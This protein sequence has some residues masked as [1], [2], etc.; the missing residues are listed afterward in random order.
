MGYNTKRERWDERNAVIIEIVHVSVRNQNRR[1][2]REGDVFTCSVWLI[3][4]G[5]N[6]PSPGINKP[7]T[8]QK[9]TTQPSA[10]FYKHQKR[11]HWS[12]RKI[13]DSGEITWRAL[14]EKSVSVWVWMEMS[15]MPEKC[16][17]ICVSFEFWG[18][19]RCVRGRRVWALHKHYSGRN[20]NA[21]K[22]L[23]DFSPLPP[24]KGSLQ[25][26]LCPPAV[27]KWAPGFLK[28]LLCQRGHQLAC[29]KFYHQLAALPL[30]LC[31]RPGH[32]EVSEGTR[33]HAERAA[34]S[35]AREETR[36]GEEVKVPTCV[37][38]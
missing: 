1:M 15:L 25:G 14:S 28:L 29:L 21:H 10:W 9:E 4:H 31:S 13:S 3:D 22:W 20:L 11:F 17:H 18:I 30:S 16:E 19:K 5:L 8:H 35:K 36:L 27:C 12:D 32:R 24:S 38:Y 6:Y 26:S 33:F 7:E 34:V 2:R 37:W 23:F